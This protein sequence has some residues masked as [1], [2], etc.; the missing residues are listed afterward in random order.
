MAITVADTAPVQA[1]TLGRSVITAL[2]IVAAVRDPFF[3]PLATIRNCGISLSAAHAAVA[4][5]PRFTTRLFSCTTT[6]IVDHFHCANSRV[7][8]G[9]LI[10]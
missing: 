4:A 6:Y 10:R 2:L 7:E 5:R 3:P 9:L 1:V 8:H